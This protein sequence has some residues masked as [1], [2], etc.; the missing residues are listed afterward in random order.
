MPPVNVFLLVQNRREFTDICLRFLFRFTDFS[1]INRLVIVNDSSIDGSLELC[2]QY[3]DEQGVGEIVNVCGNTVT[4][5]LFLGTH[6]YLDDPVKY[7]V[8]ID[9][10]FILSERWLNIV[11][12]IA[13]RYSD[14]FD[15][16][17]FPVANT[18]YQISP[19][20]L[21]RPRRADEFQMIP[22]EHTGGNF[23]MKWDVYKSIRQCGVSKNPENYITGSLCE[24]HKQLHQNGVVRI[25]ILKPFLPVFK[26]DMV[27]A[28]KYTEF[29]FFETRDI[30]RG[31]I[32]KL[33]EEYNQ[34]KFNRTRIVDGQ[35]IKDF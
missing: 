14:R 15:I 26:L 23:M 9:N 19:L 17:G 31:R 27:A 33:I 20:E 29:Q 30:D 5:A 13:E 35:M 7:M 34:K 11:Y 4:N 21:W 6:R 1:L 12:E 32:L 16:T 3:I 10:D 18:F 24:I 28:D 22:A 25:G 8:K 2:Q